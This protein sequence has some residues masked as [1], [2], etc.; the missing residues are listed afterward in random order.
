LKN[1]YDYLVQ[2][3]NSVVK[4]EKNKLRDLVRGVATRDVLSSTVAVLK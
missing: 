2:V 1:V 4:G 3:V